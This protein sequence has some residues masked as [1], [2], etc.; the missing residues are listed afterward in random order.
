LQTRCKS[1]F[2]L[3]RELSLVCH[4]ILMYRQDNTKKKIPNTTSKKNKI[5]QMLIPPLEPYKRSHYE[6]K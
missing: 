6:K 1:P 3:S 4:R 2:L 5:D